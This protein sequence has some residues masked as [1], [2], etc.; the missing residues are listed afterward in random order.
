MHPAWPIVVRYFSQRNFTF[1]SIRPRFGRRLCLPSS[2]CI[3]NC[4]I[5]RTIQTH[6]S[7]CVNLKHF[8]LPPTDQ[9][10]PYRS[11][12][13]THQ[14]VPPGFRL[15]YK[16]CPPHIKNHNGKSSVDASTHCGSSLGSCNHRGIATF[17][18]DSYFVLNWVKWCT[19][20]RWL[21]VQC[22]ERLFEANSF[23]SADATESEHRDWNIN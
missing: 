9:P 3:Q 5:T 15:D 11:I 10:P 8:I 12:R 6:L 7:Y 1:Q 22:N 13:Y 23:A 21:V 20:K 17:L 18:V 2:T 16:P 19:C 14:Q 4:Y